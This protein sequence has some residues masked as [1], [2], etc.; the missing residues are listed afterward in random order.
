M[1]ITRTADYGVRAMMHLADV[2]QGTRSSIADVAVAA[3][4][5]PGLMSKILQR[6]AKAQL[7][8]SYRGKAGGFQLAR[9]AAHISLLDIVT[10][11][12]GPLCL[13]VCLLAGDACGRRP[14]CAAHLVWADVQRKM[15]AVLGSASLEQLA[16][17]SA[18]RRTALGI[19]SG[20]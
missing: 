9:P 8:V 1:Q 7:V 11:I 15:A 5:P 19:A 3:D 13:N 17:G 16:R 20:A 10:A 4:V 14:W 18:D 12:D 6:L 2:A